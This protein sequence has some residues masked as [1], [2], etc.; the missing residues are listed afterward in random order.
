M[1]VLDMPNSSTASHLSNSNTG[2]VN[3]KRQRQ[4]IERPKNREMFGFSLIELL[5]VIGIISILASLLLPALLR[6]KEKARMTR[7]I[8]N[9]GQISMGLAM[10]AHD[11]RDRFPGGYYV[12]GTNYGLLCDIGGEDRPRNRCPNIAPAEVRPLFPYMRP[13]EVFRCTEDRGWLMALELRRPIVCK[14]TS[15][16]VTGCSYV[17]SGG[18]LPT[19]F[20]WDGWIQ[21]R[22]A[23]WVPDPSRF[24]LLCEPPAM[25]VGINNPSPHWVYTHWHEWRGWQDVLDV[26]MPKDKSKFISP[27]AFVDGHVKREDFTYNIQTT[28]PYVFEETKEWMWYKPQP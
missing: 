11:Y 21:V 3:M 15:W 22:P 9:M 6:G 16:E 25:Q 7:C 2:Q 23:S 17:Y 10:Y 19:K 8:N 5:V 13:S 24:I 27:I 14:P 12:N 18:G 4:P 20:P 1:D 26:D 28:R